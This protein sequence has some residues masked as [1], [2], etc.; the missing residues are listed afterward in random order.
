[1]LLGPSGCGKTT[2]LRIVAG[3]ERQT[4]GDVLINDEIVND[5]T[6]RARGVAMVFVGWDDGAYRASND[7]A[8]SIV[9]PKMPYGG[10]SLGTAPKLAC[11]TGPS[12]IARRLRLLPSYPS[13]GTSLPPS[14]VPSAAA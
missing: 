4:S 2:F 14:F 7:A 5:I 3:L 10:F 9:P 6:P 8:V 12:L 1:V 13:L 11:Q